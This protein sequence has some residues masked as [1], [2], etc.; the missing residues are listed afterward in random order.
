MF[1]NIWFLYRGSQPGRLE[2]PSEEERW[3]RGGELTSRNLNEIQIKKD[4]G[5]GRHI[6]SRLGLLHSFV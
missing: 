5:C 2:S 3:S 4:V 1:L 6:Y